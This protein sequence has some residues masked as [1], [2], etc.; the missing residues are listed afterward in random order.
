MWEIL[1]S[2]SWFSFCCKNAAH[3][4][5]LVISLSL[6]AYAGST[7]WILDWAG[8]LSQFFMLW[9]CSKTQ[10]P[11]WVSCENI[12]C[13]AW[14]FILATSLVP[15][16]PGASSSPVVYQPWN[17]AMAQT[18]KP[19]VLLYSFHTFALA[20][21]FWKGSLHISLNSILSVHF[22]FGRQNPR[23]LQFFRTQKMCFLPDSWAGII[24]LWAKFTIRSQ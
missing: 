12:F 14:L 3:S 21:F 1:Y 23:I 8:G 20:E 7:V 15:N 17:R 5:C 4:L 2:Q 9:R 19:A 24:I 18:E 11:A 16:S 13:R 22:P 10:L 6:I